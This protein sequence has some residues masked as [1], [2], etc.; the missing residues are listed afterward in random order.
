MLIDGQ[1]I[2]DLI[3][4]YSTLQVSGREL[5]SQSIEKQ[6]IGKTD[7]E[8]IQYV[9]NPSR[10]IVVGY[11]LAAD[12]SLSFRQAFYKLN[13]ILHGD[14]HQVSFNDDPSKYWIAT[15]SD[16]DDVPKGRNA[17]T[18]SFT[19]FVPDGVAH[20]VATK[21]ADNMGDDGT[22]NDEITIQNDGTYPVYPVISAT[23]HGDNGLVAFA[24]DQGGVLQFGDPEEIDGET[25]ERSERALREGMDT[26]PSGM[27]MNQSA[28]NYPDYIGT[29]NPNVQ[30]GAVAFGTDNSA[31]DPAGGYEC[32]P[33]YGT[34]A[35]GVWSGP[36]LY[37]PIKP[38]TAT[39]AAGNFVMKTRFSF[40]ALVANAGRLE[41]NL[42]NG[43]AV[44][45]G[46]I[47]R[48][49]SA[50][51]DKMFLEFW[52]GSTRVSNME[53][54]KKKFTN[55]SY[56]ELVISR[57]GNTVTFTISVQTGISAGNV[58]V[59]QSPISVPWTLTD[60]AN[61]PVDGWSAW[62]MRFPGLTPTPMSLSDLQFDWANVDYWSDLPN[63]F[64]TGD[65]VTADVASKTI[66]VNG[67]EDMT[68]HTVGNTW[69]KF[70]LHPGENTIQT[71]GSSWCTTPLEVNVQYREAYY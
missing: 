16:I 49:S 25:K 8:F 29:T 53:L 3:P 40:A 56:K 70:M 10:E 51:D 43:D 67:V 14:S 52:V 9:R 57:F 6:T 18:S 42:Q 33:V 7:G 50:L 44:A 46:A 21:T 39:G 69:D 23:M 32:Q 37:L 36:S 66:Y 60:E 13:S 38:N 30:T 12:D 47:L 71:I 58:A 26:A 19:L 4:G 28:S 54:D 24:N 27:V 17:I 61:V 65:V 34:A 64:S 35:A 59:V 55:G 5:L 20:S 41:V 63:R 11:R 45:Y 2:E 31:K 68:L 15:F 1:Y 22:L 48:D 62:F